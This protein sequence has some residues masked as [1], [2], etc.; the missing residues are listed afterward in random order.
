LSIY[1]GFVSFPF[2]G[3]LWIGR[4]VGADLFLLGS[5]ESQQ[6]DVIAPIFFIQ[7]NIIRNGIVLKNRKNICEKKTKWLDESQNGEYL[8]N[9][10]FIGLK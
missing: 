2:Y 4:V 5:S 3:C 9:T 1:V 8:F 6:T 7:L 10:K